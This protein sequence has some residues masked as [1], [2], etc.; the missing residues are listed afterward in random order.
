MERD[1]ERERREDEE[2]KS[3]LDTAK[4]SLYAPDAPLIT[5]RRE[6]QDAYQY[7]E[8]IK[9]PEQK[10]NPVVQR[11]FK[12]KGETVDKVS[13]VFRKILLGAVIFF[14]LSVGAAVFFYFFGNNIISSRNIAININTPTSVASSDTLSFEVSIQNG[15][16]SDLINSAI[17]ID[18][19]D[20]TR[21]VMDNTKPLISQKVDIGTLRKGEIAKRTI[22]TR[23]F[24]PENSTKTIKVTYEYNIADSNGNF[25][26][27]ESFNVTLR[28]APVVFSVNALTE[29]NNN[30]E[31]TLTANVISNSNNMLRNVAVN[32]IYPFG[33][34]YTE[35]NLEV[36][37]GR[38]GLFPIGDLSPNETKQVVVKG[39]ISGQS[40]DDKVFK[41]NVG[42]ADAQSPERISTSL[43]TYD[44][45]MTIRT[46]F[47][48]TKIVLSSDRDGQPLGSPIRGTVSWRNTLDVPLND[49]RFSLR[50]D[51]DLIDIPAIT[52]DRGFYDSS[53]SMILWNQDENKELQ[54]VAPG[55][56][57][58]YG[59]SIPLF[60]YDRAISTKLHN[61]QVDLQLDVQAR[62][63][64]A[65]NVSEN[66][67]S[68]FIKNVPAKTSVMLTAQSLH[69][70]GPLSNTGP[71]PPKAEQKT[72]YT[73][74]IALSNSVNPMAG[75]V[76][77]VNLPTYVTYE[78]Q[79]SPQSERVSWNQGSRQVRW[80]IGDIATFTG[81]G[82]SPRSL[83]FRVGISP[84]RTQ[85]GQVLD[86]VRDISFTGQDASA[87]VTISATAPT[88]T[89]MAKDQAAGS[90]SGQVVQ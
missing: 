31:I 41:F 42:T 29:V 75:G 88:V 6:M 79:I 82:I 37:T 32:V 90:N 45:N 3:R 49:V 66:I 22:S 72:T 87:G 59:F 39:I 8:E 78:D 5:H 83:S 33:F 62:R 77:T 19:P 47:L 61:P 54:E 64:D 18:Y 14:I 10:W 65:D 84:S 11:D 43:A 40:E 26:K 70:T 68:S 71:I 2:R 7:D 86:L 34:T 44:Q 60:A 57:G 56:S 13:K 36:A 52:S 46:D 85:I 67:T 23:L 9:V 12:P 25:S 55:Q 74:T 35:S 80:D 20:G 28:L 1:L 16:N 17:V 38:D 81:H 30:Q 51:G 48:A 69:L 27:S 21:E 89:T 15:N 50:I 73:V 63:L 53:G 24:G 58:Q 4:D 76:V